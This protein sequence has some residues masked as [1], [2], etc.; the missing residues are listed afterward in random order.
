MSIPSTCIGAYPK[1]EYLPNSDWF[2]TEPG[3]NAPCS[4]ACDEGALTG[5]EAE[6]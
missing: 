2:Q 3:T 5:M 1:P 6:A 4:T